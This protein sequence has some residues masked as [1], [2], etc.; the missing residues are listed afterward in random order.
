MT[1]EEIPEGSKRIY[2]AKIFVE[3]TRIKYKKKYKEKYSFEDVYKEGE[4][5]N[6]NSYFMS[7][8]KIKIGLNKDEEEF[9]IVEIKKIK[10]VGYSIPQT[11]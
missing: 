3:I 2:L 1:E 7:M 6:K 8:V 10:Y 9:K 5:K 11:T 4:E